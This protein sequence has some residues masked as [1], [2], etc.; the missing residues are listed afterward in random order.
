MRKIE[1]GASPDFFE[2]WKKKFIAKNKRVATYSDLVGKQKQQL[3]EVLY[4]EQYGLCCYCCKLLQ[5]P[6]P[7]D[8]NI[9]IEHFRPQDSYKDLDLDYGNLH[10]SCSGYKN[11]GENCG[12]KKDNWF[13]EKLT[14]SPLENDVESLFTYTVDGHIRAAK[15]NI[16]AKTTIC[17]LGLDSYALQRMRKTAVYICGLFDEDFDEEK[18]NRILNEYQTPMD[19]VLKSFCNAVIFCVE[20]A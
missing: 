17:K 15:G 12:H 1:K 7:Y 18:K 14:V 3:K 9:H 11:M 2:D 8:E 10:I 13:D 16:R 4:D 5:Y 6:Y 20:N 19:G